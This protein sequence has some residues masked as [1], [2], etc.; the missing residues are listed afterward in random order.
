MEIN[1]G[2]EDVDGMGE[3]ERQGGRREEQ[4]MEMMVK[5]G[6]ME[7]MGKDERKK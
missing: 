1:E 3:W 5:M 6:R 2:W 4:D 7:I